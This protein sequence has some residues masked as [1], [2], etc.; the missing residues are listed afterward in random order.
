M[1]RAPHRVE[2]LVISVPANL[3]LIHEVRDRFGAWF[4][5]WAD[6]RPG[7]RDDLLV[8]ISELLANAAAAAPDVGSE[9]RLEARREGEDAVVEVTNPVTPWIDAAIRWDLHDPLRAGGRGL[10]IVRALVDEISVV[11]DLIANV[12]TLRCRRSTAAE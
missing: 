7:P 5:S 4:D 10:L 8:V 9:L 2:D 3:A 1:P 6:D 12:T 11:Q